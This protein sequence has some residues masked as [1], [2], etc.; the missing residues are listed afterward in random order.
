MV[1]QTVGRNIVGC[2]M[3]GNL[4]QLKVAKIILNSE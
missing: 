1:S 4:A 2:Y 3:M